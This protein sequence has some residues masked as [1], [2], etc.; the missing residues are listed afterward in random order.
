MNTLFSKIISGEI[1]CHKIAESNQ[2][3]AFLDISPLAKGHT[4]VIPKNPVDYIFDMED[5]VY[6]DMWIF[7]KSVSAMIKNAIP[8]TKVGVAVIGLEVAHAHIHLVPIN[9][10]SDINFAAPKLSLSQEE[11]AEIASKINS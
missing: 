7:A 3:L 6:A 11:L 10:V 5:T 8:C 1:P 4:L 2:F 9:S